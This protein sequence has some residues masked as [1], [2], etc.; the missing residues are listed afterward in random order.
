[1]IFV[2]AKIQ[3]RLL[4]QVWAN[5]TKMSFEAEAYVC[6]KSLQIKCFWKNL[7]LKHKWAYFE[8]EKNVVKYMI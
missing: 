3:K 6:E 5:S 2:W 1:M 8:Y 4:C 7:L